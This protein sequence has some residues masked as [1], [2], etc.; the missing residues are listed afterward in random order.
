MSSASAIK[1][2]AIS[3]MLMSSLHQAITQPDETTHQDEE[4]K[5]QAEEENICHQ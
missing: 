3:T 2:A 1:P 4:A 5:H